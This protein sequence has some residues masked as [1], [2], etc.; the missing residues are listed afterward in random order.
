MADLIKGVS[1]DAQGAM[2]AKLATSC[3]DAKDVKKMAIKLAAK[4]ELTALG[5]PELA[6]FEIPYFQSDGKKNCFK[7]WRYLQDTRTGFAAQTDAKPL[8]YIQAKSTQP[9]IYLPPHADWQAIMKDVTVPVIITEGE[10]KAACCTKLTAPCI[11]LGGVYS[12]KSSKAVQM[13]IPA[14]KA[15]EWENRAVTIAFD[16]DAS[17]NEMVVKARNE[18][19]RTLTGLGAIIYIANVPP[20]EEGGKQGIDDLAYTGGVDALVAVLNSAESFSMSEELHALNEEIAYVRSIGIVVVVED[21]HMMKPYDFTA[22]QYADRFYETRT[23]DAKGNTKVAM[24]PLA[25]A[26]LEWP[27]RSVLKKVAYQPGLDRITE[28][29]EYNT[30]KGWKCEPKKGDV[31]PWKELLDHLFGDDKK[32]KDWFERWCAYPIQ[33]PGAKM[34]TAAVLW[35][36][37]TGTG[38]SFV[39][40]SLGEIYGQNFTE[41]GDAELLDERREW[42][43]EKQFIL[44]DDVAGHEQRKFA[45]RI[46]KMITQK[47]IRINKKYIPSYTEI[48]VLNYLFTSNNSDAFFLE[49]ND[50]RFFIHE[51]LAGP[52]DPE[53]YKAYEKWIYGGGAAHLFYHLLHLDLGEM[54]AT[55]RAPDTAAKQSMIHDG[56]SDVGSWVRQLR[57][58]PGSVL[59]VGDVE[60]SGA[61]W[62]S[63]DLVRLYDPQEKGRVT[64]NG[65]ARELKRAGL[66]Q[67][68]SGAPVPT[69]QGQRRLFIIKDVE[70]WL[71]EGSK[72][73]AAEY[74]AARTPIERKKKF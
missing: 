65:M 2:L 21:G 44:G 61:L 34:Y 11:G 35:G 4:G 48:D 40:Y 72:S 20:T 55:D 17:S 6:A 8:R 37:A 16:S 18:L 46:K 29:S 60:L 30:W 31:K 63:A 5:F 19:A 53:F 41:I 62:T 33:H 64:A 70:R 51:V 27:M 58:D 7:R 15:F 12:F 1:F 59:K 25:K 73:L 50:R 39:G 69:L 3:L 74:D 24:K 22:H 43:T 26:W 52:K 66:R 47:E 10:L 38:K 42:A 71:K 36:V 68:Y 57:D 67:A 13:L 45:D 49:D 14:L 23:Q 56:L 9:E 32:A 54:L 28:N